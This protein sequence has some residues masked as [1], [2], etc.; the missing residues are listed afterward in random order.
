MLLTQLLTKAVPR[1]YQGCTIL[2]PSL[3]HLFPWILHFLRKKSRSVLPQ[4]DKIRS[5]DP[6]LEANKKGTWH[7]HTPIM[8]I[9]FVSQSFTGEKETDSSQLPVLYIY[10]E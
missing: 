10:G 5:F 3:H 9:F 7:I 6:C 4:S 1:P 2:A 8:G